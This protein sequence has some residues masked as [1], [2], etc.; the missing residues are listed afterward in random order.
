MTTP[1][2]KICS[3]SLSVSGT[4]LHGAFFLT[5]RMDKQRRL[6]WYRL[7]NTGEPPPSF[8]ARKPAILIP[9]HSECAVATQNLVTVDSQKQN[10]WSRKQQHLFAKACERLSYTCLLKATL[11][12]VKAS[13]KLLSR[14]ISRPTTLEGI[15]TTTQVPK[16]FEE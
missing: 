4:I 3:M 11:D 14:L 15:G 10:L 12:M 5:R 2:G 6:E 1:S 8:K 9:A 13:S 7:G 16:F